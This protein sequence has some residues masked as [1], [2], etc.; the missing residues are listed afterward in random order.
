MSRDL[1]ARKPAGARRASEPRLDT[2]RSLF[3]AVHGFAS[4]AAAIAASRRDIQQN[5][6]PSRTGLSKRAARC[7]AWA[8]APRNGTL[9]VK[10][11]SRAKAVP[12]IK[13]KKLQILAMFS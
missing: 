10:M 12:E 3:V 9:G 6:A 4:G 11:T 1:K 7:S 5:T 2:V 8:L 13:L